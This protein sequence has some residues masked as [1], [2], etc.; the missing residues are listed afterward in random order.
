MCVFFLLGA[1]T[2]NKLILKFP[3][4]AHTR[5]LGGYGIGVNR[6]RAIYFNAQADESSSSNPPTQPPT[7]T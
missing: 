1:T 6:V 2:E 3:A 7:P 5:T 4:R